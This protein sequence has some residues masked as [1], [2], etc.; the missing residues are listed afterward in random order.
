MYR[1]NT[2]IFNGCFIGELT[3]SFLTE[4]NP[5]PVRGVKHREGE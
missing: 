1:E 2:K 5:D 3:R 4:P